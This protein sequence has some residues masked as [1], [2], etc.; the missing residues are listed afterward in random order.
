MSATRV[1]LVRHGETDWNAR[2]VYQGWRDVPLNARGRLQARALATSLADVAIDAAYSSPLAR[3]RETAEIAL[4]ARFVRARSVSALRELSYGEWEG[5][6]PEERRAGWPLLEER[7]TTDPWRV[8][9]P[10]GESLDTLA[11][12]VLPVWEKLLAAHA[13][14]TILLCGH[15]HLNRV[16]V[17]HA[18]RLPRAEFWTVAQ[19]NGSATMLECVPAAEFAEVAG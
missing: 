16:I 13:G 14:E 17:L 10:G 5:L 6:A 2:G 18:R 3:A 4:G 19:P 8:Q 7:W 1:L 9:F 12:R 15:G 11:G